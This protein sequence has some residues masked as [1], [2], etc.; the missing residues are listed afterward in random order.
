MSTDAQA[1]MAAFFKM[2][3]RLFDGLTDKIDALGHAIGRN[4]YD[5][6]GLYFR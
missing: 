2:G 3:Y 5:F 1:Q 6:D 4:E